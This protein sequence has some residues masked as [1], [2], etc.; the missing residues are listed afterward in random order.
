MSREVLDLNYEGA[1]PISIIAPKFKEKPKLPFKPRA[2]EET[3]FGN[4]ARKDGLI[5]K[6]WRRK[7]DTTNVGQLPV[8]PADSN[9]ASEM[10]QD[11][12]ATTIPD[13]HWSKYNVRVPR[14]QYTDEQYE[15]H[16]MSEDWSRE[17]TDYLL[18][19]AI[20]FDLRWIVISDR[21]DYQPREAFNENEESM[22]VVP[23]AKPR[24]QEDLK[25]RYYTVAAKA[26]VL[27][28][29]KEKMTP[30][31]FEAHTKMEGYDPQQEK[32]RKVYAEQLLA[33]TEEEKHEEEFLL[34]ELSRIVLNQ[35]KL[36]NERK[37][38]YERLDAPKTTQND[39]YSTTMYQSSAGLTQLM[40]MQM[41]Q[42]RAKEMEKKA[43]R[44]SMGLDEAGRDNNDRQRPSMDNNKRASIGAANTPHPRNLSL[45]EQQR[46]GVA[47]PTNER[48]VGGVTFRNE[49]AQ[50]AAQA[51]SSVQTTR[52]NAA[53]TELNIPPRLTMPTTKVVAEYEKLIES[54][55]G[56][57]E[58]RKLN[59]KIEG[60]IKTARAQ[61]EAEEAKARGEEVEEKKEGEGETKVE[62]EEEEDNNEE[63]VKKRE[64]ER[65]SEE[66][67]DAEG[68]TQNNEDEDEENEGDGE[69][70]ENAQAE[71]ALN[72]MADDE[73]DDGDP[74]AE[75]DDDDGAENEEDE[76]REEDAEAEEDAEGDDDEGAEAADAEAD[77]GV[78]E[79]GDDE[80]DEEAEV[81]EADGEGDEI[82]E[83]GEGGEAEENDDGPSPAPTTRS[84]R[85]RSASITS[86]VSSKRQKK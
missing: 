37:A 41:N 77:A 14:P 19:L 85:K 78:E 33:R 31:E 68:E 80:E 50:K 86:A 64:A 57:L 7:G 83:D 62:E 12:K 2:W 51:K 35:E 56:L 38:L 79:L 24:T 18:D 49:R 69:G 76:E 23:Q 70:E 4:S 16:M 42:N 13:A 47:Y 48:L 10:D 52:I 71:R 44:Q 54:V 17:E 9:A 28:I 73:D 3:P 84:T 43:K 27:R 30:A 46:Y 66:E 21:Y 29:P 1:P 5:L 36:F 15:Q 40:Q 58:V 72:D 6:H 32:R 34:K 39:N 45:R 59:E 55:K 20:E 60:E 74:Q 67:E 25:S 63:E 8:T 82:E 22:A 75:A 11:D 53:L 81:E 65:D 61:K 26:M